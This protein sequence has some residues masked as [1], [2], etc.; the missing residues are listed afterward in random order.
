MF[1]NI[2]IAGGFMEWISTFCEYFDRGTALNNDMM[3]ITV[4]LN[5]ALVVI[6]EEG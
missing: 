4:L 2:F 1:P 3:I 5:S 6:L